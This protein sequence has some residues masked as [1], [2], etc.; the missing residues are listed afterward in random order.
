MIERARDLACRWNRPARAARGC[1]CARPRARTPAARLR[2][3]TP[4]PTR[5]TARS[6]PGPRSTSVRTAAGSHS[7]SPAASVSCSCSATSSSSLSA[8]AMPPC[9]YSEEDSAGCPWPPPARGPPRPVRWPRASRRRPRRPPGNPV[10]CAVFRYSQRSRTMVQRLY[11][12]LC[13]DTPQRRYRAIVERGILEPRRRATSRAR[14]GRAFRRHHR[15]RLGAPRRGAS[16]AALAGRTH[17]ILFFPAAK[18]DKRLAAVEALADEMVRRGGDR[19]S[20]VIA[21]GGGIVTDVGGFLAAIFMRGIPVLQIPTTLLAQVDAGDR[22]Q[23]RRE[24]RVRQKPGRRV[25]SAACRADRSRT[26]SRTLP[27]REYRAGLFEVIKCGIIRSPDCSDLMAGN[28]PAC[29][30][31]TP[32]VVE[33]MIAESVRIKAEVVSADEREGGLRA[34]PQFRPHRRPRAGSRDRLHALP[35]RRGGGLRHARRRVSRERTRA[36]VAPTHARRHPGRGRRSTARFRRW[37]AS[38]PDEPRSRR[39]RDKKTAAG[40]GALRAARRDRRSEDRF[41]ARRDHGPHGH[42]GSPRHE[43]MRRGPRR[44][45]R[46]ANRKPLAG[47]AACSAASPAATTCSTTCCRSTSTATG[48]RRTVRVVRPVLRRPGARVLDL[49]CGTGDLLLWRSNAPR[50]RRR[51]GQR[52]LPPHAGRGRAASSRAGGLP[53]VAV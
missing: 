5:S 18:S 24:S 37:T 52:F 26:C 36:P 16:T 44:R 28:A 9:A 38:P 8:T 1:G 25:P 53:L 41:R 29:S 21:F 4:R 11:A 45:E 47:C 34:H 31:A 51:D 14:A 40:Q 7:P 42:S 35:A 46:T 50:G 39:C 43:R 13:V 12:F 3:R 27:E 6:R 20:L 30:P 15:R 48:A 49:C 33:R 32:E 17:E 2:G 10:H 19:S 23:D 22:R